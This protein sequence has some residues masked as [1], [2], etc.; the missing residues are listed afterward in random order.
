VNT[1]LLLFSL[2]SGWEYS[3]ERLLGLITMKASAMRDDRKWTFPLVMPSSI[4]LRKFTKTHPKA[5]F[6]KESDHFAHFL[7]FDRTLTEQETDLWRMFLV[8]FMVHENLTRKL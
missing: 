8:G 7:V 4:E 6:F 5:W 1:K 3:P 2:P